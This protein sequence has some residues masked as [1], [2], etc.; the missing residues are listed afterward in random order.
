[1]DI[2]PSEAETFWAAFLRKLARRGRRD[3]N[4]V[5]ENVVRLG[6]GAGSEHLH[7]AEV[8]AEVIPVSTFAPYVGSRLGLEL[9]IG[10]DV[11]LRG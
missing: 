2:G 3:V 11:I 6:M 1:M 5:I 9:Q 7:D 10:R 4:M 8:Q